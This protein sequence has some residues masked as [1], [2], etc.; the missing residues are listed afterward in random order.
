MNW[1]KGEQSVNWTKLKTLIRLFRVPLLS[2]VVL[3]ALRLL[4][5]PSGPGLEKIESLYQSG[6]LQAARQGLEQALNKEPA[7]HEAREILVRV[8]LADGRPLVALEH[9]HVLALAEWDARYYIYFEE[10][11]Q[12]FSCSGCPECD[13][14]SRISICSDW[15]TLWRV[16][17]EME[18][19]PDQVRSSSIGVNHV[20]LLE[21]LPR[22]YEKWT[23]VHVDFPQDSLAALGRAGAMPTPQ[24]LDW[25][26]EWEKQTGIEIHPLYSSYKTKLIVAAA[27]IQ[28]IYLTNL[29]PENLLEIILTDPENIGKKTLAIEELQQNSTVPARIKAA[30]TTED[31]PKWTLGECLYYR[32]IDE[33]AVLVL[34]AE[35]NTRL[36]DF[37]NGDSYPYPGT[38]LHW[39]P[40]G[41][42]AALSEGSLATVINRR[43]EQV[44]R[45]PL[46]QGLSILGWKSQ[47]SLWVIF[48]E[49][50]LTT[51]FATAS[52]H[53]VNLEDF[54]VQKLE[55]FPELRQGAEYYAG[56]AG[57]IAWRQGNT[58]GLW[59]GTDSIA[60][61][62]AGDVWDVS[63]IPDGSG[64]VFAMSD[65]Y[66]L[67]KY[68]GELVEIVPGGEDWGKF[69]GWRNPQEMY[70]QYPTGI[71]HYRVLAL[72]N[73]ESQELTL[74]GIINPSQA[75][76]ERIAV[77]VSNDDSSIELQIYQLDETD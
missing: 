44:E 47:N 25:L 70:F 34:D 5:A 13:Q 36:V 15:S 8:E 62:Y 56:P 2:I 73:L 38:D 27:D 42:L 59:N 58:L 32:L 3:L 17:Q 29:E 68:D 51:T 33:R 41:K 52:V 46:D 61:N 11:L 26:A 65:R 21:T 40:D 10:I 14:N 37:E 19:F 45:F 63:W 48:Q 16:V 24:G 7:R 30:L 55:E 20:L 75:A 50:D 12:S 9:L 66:W 54:T 77:G 6:Q 72:Y 60:N 22:D 31:K 53:V 23:Q 76:G 49:F 74:T 28:A 57:Q 67:Q 71:G 69:L 1:S 18:T 43:G 64:V 4:Y 39:S 35:Y